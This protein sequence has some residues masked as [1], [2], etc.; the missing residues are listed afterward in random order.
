[1]KNTREDL[2]FHQCTPD[3]LDAFYPVAPAFSD[4]MARFRSNPTLFCFDDDMLI[5]GQDTTKFSR[6]DLNLVPCETCNV[7]LK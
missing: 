6:V 2:G 1:M 7:T 4:V 3:E 5:H